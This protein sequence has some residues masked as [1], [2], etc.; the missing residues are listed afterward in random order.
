MGN[1]ILDLSNNNARPD[2]GAVARWRKTID[3]VKYA[4]DGVILKASEGATFVDGVYREWARAARRAG[5]RVGAYHYARPEGGDA[6]REARHFVACMG[7]LKPGDYRPWLD[8]E[9]NDG[10]L[11]RSQLVAWSREFNQECFKLSGHLPGIYASKSWL[12]SM[13]PTEP[14]GA[15]LWLAWWSSNGMPFQPKPPAPWKRVQ[16][17]QFTSEAT[18]RSPLHPDGVPGRVDINRIYRLRPLLAFPDEL[19]V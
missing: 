3:G 11:S 6:R 15:A 2:F 16:L 7:A 5:L 13:R 17:H 18:V 8:L 19:D 4:V 1:L 12:D 10:G 9:E 14:I